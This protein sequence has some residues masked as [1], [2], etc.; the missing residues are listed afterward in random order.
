MTYSLVANGRS[1]ISAGVSH[2]TQSAA[3]LRRLRLRSVRCELPAIRYVNLEREAL[4]RQL[5]PNDIQDL[6]RLSGA[7]GWNQTA[8]D[9]LRVLGLAPAGCWGIENEGRIIATTTLICYGTQLAWVGMVLTDAEI[10]GKGFA[11]RLIR[12]A[13]DRAHHLGVGCV[14]LD[15]TAVGRSLYE[16]LGFRPEQTVERWHRK[17]LGGSVHVRG[18]TLSLNTELDRSACG[19]D[20]TA[21]LEAMRLEGGTYVQTGGFLLTRSGSLNGYLGP[22]VA[23][24]RETARALL[25]QA[26]SDNPDSGWF[27][28]LL[29][30]NREA[31]RL[32]RSFAFA[33]CRTLTRMQMGESLAAEEAAVY[34]IAGFELG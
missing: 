13:L 15:A 12:H 25:E 32:A 11:T 27:W 33:P 20:R 34:A 18:T 1:R 21:W 22:Y 29:P 9:W 17:G 31:Q 2:E 3:R 19:Y 14:K 6:L 8:A 24:D 5:H 10:R 16:K 30:G 28:D 26:L 7:A 23:R 4:L